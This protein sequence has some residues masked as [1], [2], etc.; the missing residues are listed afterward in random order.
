MLLVPTVLQH[1]LVAEVEEEEKRNEPPT[2]PKNT[3]NGRFTNFVN[4][5]DMAAI[6]VP[7][8]VIT[9]PSMAHGEHGPS[10]ALLLS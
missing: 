1:Y 4:L 6:S 2:W 7:S 3:L 9:H 10:T 8:T 5:L